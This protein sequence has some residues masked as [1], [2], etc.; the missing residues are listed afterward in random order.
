MVVPRSATVI[1]QDDEYILYNPT[2][3]K[4]YL[5]E[6]TLKAREHKWT[7]REFEYSEEHISDL[8]QE[9]QKA[10]ELERKLWGDVV[11]L[12]QTSYQDIVQN[13]CYLKAIRIY[14]E[15]VLRYGL[16]PN[17]LNT[18]LCVPEKN[19]KNTVEILF[20]KFGYLGGNAFA[21]KKGKKKTGEDTDLH[22]YGAIVDSDYKPFVIEELNLF[23]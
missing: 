17:F 13:W 15:A 7:P 5:H 10:T 23:A 19:V 12:V 14:V 20:K 21:N 22:E 4:K 3:F 1:A 16:P 2:L 9:L 6:F 8:R 18:A 11:R